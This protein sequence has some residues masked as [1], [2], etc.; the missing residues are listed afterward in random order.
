MMQ[1][2]A[3]ME[4]ESFI[5][6]LGRLQNGWNIVEYMSLQEGQDPINH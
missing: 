5:A 6:I 1:N 2:K 4:D 3:E